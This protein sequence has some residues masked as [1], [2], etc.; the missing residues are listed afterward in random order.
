M[1]TVLRFI[2]NLRNLKPLLKK[3]KSL[4]IVLLLAIFLWLLFSKQDSVK[5]KLNMEYQSQSK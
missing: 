1:K 3:D 5:F 2:F 4:L